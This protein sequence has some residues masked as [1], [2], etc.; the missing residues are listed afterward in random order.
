MLKPISEEPEKPKPEP[1]QVKPPEPKEVKPPPKE[2]PKEAPKEMTLQEQ[3]AAKR[4]AMIRRE[5]ER[6]N[7]PK[8]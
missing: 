8:V 5:T 2:A 4:E 3:L 7:S 1:K 6:Q